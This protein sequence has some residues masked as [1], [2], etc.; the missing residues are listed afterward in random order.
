MSRVAVLPVPG[1]RPGWSATSGHLIAAAADFGLHDAA[2]TYACSMYD[3]GANQGPTDKL[4]FVQ[5]HLN[6]VKI[7]RQRGKVTP[8]ESTARSCFTPSKKGLTLSE[9]AETGLHD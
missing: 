2:H 5:I 1:L 9:C 4:L 3:V 7:L 6:S 8:D